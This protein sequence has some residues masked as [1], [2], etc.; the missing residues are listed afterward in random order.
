MGSLGDHRLEQFADDAL[1]V[2]LAEAMQ[3]RKAGVAAD[4]SDDEDDPPCLYR[5]LGHPMD[6]TAQPSLAPEACRGLPTTRK[7]SAD[8][9][10]RQIM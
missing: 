9:D 5:T 8:L 1:G 10:R 4:V 6:A 2:G 7:G 3:P